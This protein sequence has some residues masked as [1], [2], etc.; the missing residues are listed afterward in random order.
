LPGASKIKTEIVNA[1]N[2]EEIKN[3]INRYFDSLE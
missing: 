2:I 3:I 1:Q